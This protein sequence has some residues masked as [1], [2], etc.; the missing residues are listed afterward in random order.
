MDSIAFGVLVAYYNRHIDLTTFVKKYFIYFSLVLALDV[1]VCA[2]LYLRYDDLF[3]IKHSL[4]ALF[5][6]IC[7]VFA[8]TL[9]GSLYAK[10]LRNK[11]LVWI[12]TLSYSLYLFH[13]LI[14]GILQY[15]VGKNELPIIANG[16]DIIITIVAF[17]ISVLF[18]WVV[19]K[20]FETPMVKL[21][22]R[23]EF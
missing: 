10:I 23:Y 4:F 17:I 11:L 9:K 7:L 16:R 1:A 14:L 13:C 19:F 2:F 12:G 22:K 20:V 6:S 15:V 8:L 3:A 5:F 18:A 21:G